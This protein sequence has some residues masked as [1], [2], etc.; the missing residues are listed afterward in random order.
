MGV[1]N[2]WFFMQNTPKLS[3][4]LGSEGHISLRNEQY[5]QDFGIE[6]S[7]YGH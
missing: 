7:M 6:G 3:N 2:G 1:E 4:D 5:V